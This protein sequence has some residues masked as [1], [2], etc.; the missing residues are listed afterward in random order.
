MLQ[1]E[2]KLML[3][4]MI[5]LEDYFTLETFNSKLENLE[6]G[7]VESKNRPTTISLKTLS[8][9]GNSL[10]QNGWCIVY[11]CSVFNISFSFTDVAFRTDAT[12]CYWRART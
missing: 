8:S 2:L 10:K 4:Y 3:Q 9:N 5:N 11:F 1:Y 6:L 7:N 12:T